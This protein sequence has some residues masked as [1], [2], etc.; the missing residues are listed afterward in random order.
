LTEEISSVVL[1]TFLYL[2]MPYPQQPFVKVR[3][4]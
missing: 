2:I 3:A 4:N 1:V